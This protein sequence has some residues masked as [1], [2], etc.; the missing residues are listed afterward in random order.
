MVERLKSVEDS[1]KSAH[2]RIDAV[3]EDQKI[4]HEMNTNI[5]LLA[6]QGTTQACEIKDI[7]CDVKELKEKPGK[8]WD[9]I[10]T[11]IITTIASSAVTAAI[12]MFS[13]KIP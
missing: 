12:V 6:Q 5:K 9:L 1:T 13:Q 8:R 7:K 3:K 4:L 10:I 11:V 2:H